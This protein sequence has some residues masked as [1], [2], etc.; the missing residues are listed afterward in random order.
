MRELNIEF[1]EQ[2]KHLDKLCKEMYSSNEGVSLYLQD[3]ERTPYSERRAVFDW[4][5]VYKKL[6]HARW[7]RNQLAH[8]IDIDTSFCEQD[9]IDWVKAF[10]K[11]ILSGTDPLACA[12]RAR[13]ETTAKRNSYKYEVAPTVNI[14]EE[15]P[16]KSFWGSLV[17]KIK[18]W[19][20]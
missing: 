13:Q 2:Y 14:I 3:M 9:D 8:E 5:I 1:Q 20:S 16:R 19:F 17:S 11:K 4:D 18:S 10:Y 6:K 12:Y 7:M 15:K